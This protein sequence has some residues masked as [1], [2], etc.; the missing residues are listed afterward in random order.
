MRCARSACARRYLNS[1]LDFAE[2]ADV[3]RAM[4]DGDLD[5]LYVAPERLVTPRCL[6][7]LAKSRHRAVRHR[8]GALRVAMGT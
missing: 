4:R 5:L 3:E 2:A 1:S 8:R 6:D 7:L